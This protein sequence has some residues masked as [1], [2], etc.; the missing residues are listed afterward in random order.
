MSPEELSSIHPRLYHITR[1][2][3]LSSI[4]KHGLLPASDLL[5]LFDVPSAQRELLETQ[6]RPVSVA[7]QHPAYGEATLT[8]NAPLSE[9]ALSKCLD[10]DLEPWDWIRLLNQR[11]FFWVDEKSLNSHLI[12]NIK[13]GEQRVVL[14][15]DTL[16]LVS[17]CHKKVE[18]AAINTGST[19]RR[20][21]RRGLSTFAPAHLY[22][23]RE[24][25]QLR[26][27]R[28]RIKELTVKGTVR[29]VDAHM[30]G[31]YTIGG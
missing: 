1:P 30:I 15:F 20:P 28:D 16:S 21:A 3:A 18:L 7:I 13:H 19:I 22:S 6:R 17:A 2:N 24:W 31:H 26:G 10:D 8:D 5:T 14:A 27:G 23:Y 12:A 29:D 25:Q 9:V 11:V 4:R